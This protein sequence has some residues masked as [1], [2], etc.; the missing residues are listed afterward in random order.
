MLSA[1]VSDSRYAALNDYALN[2][3]AGACGTAELLLATALPPGVPAQLGWDLAGASA[4]A[5]ADAAATAAVL[6][7]FHLSLADLAAAQAGLAA[8]GVG[9]TV[10]AAAESFGIYS[11]ALTHALS[12]VAADPLNSTHWSSLADAAVAALSGTQSATGNGTSLGGVASNVGALFSYNGPIPIPPLDAFVAAHTLIRGLFS[13]YEPAWAAYKAV[14]EKLGYNPLGNMVELGGVAFVPDSPGVRSMAASLAARHVSWS[15]RYRGAFADV[16]T[17]RDAAAGGDAVVGPWAVVVFDEATPAAL[18]YTIRMRFTLVPDTN[19]VA[20][21][22]YGGLGSAYLKYY[23]SGFLSLQ[24][25]IDEA[26]LAGALGPLNRTVGNGT[27]LLW[28]TPFPVFSFERN[29]FYESSGPLLGLVMCLSLVYPVG[30]LI[31]ALVEEKESGLRELMRVSG[32]CHWALGAAWALTYVV[33]FIAVSIAATVVLASSVFPHTSVTILW[34]LLF[35]FMLSCVPLCFLVSTAFR[36]ARLASIFGPF[37]LF[38]L[39]LPRYI[40]FR[41]SAGQAIGG[42]RAACLLAPT[43]FTFAADALSR[44]EAG[45]SGVTTAN[46]LDGPLPVGECMAWMVLDTMLY[47]LLASFFDYLVPDAVRSGRFARR[48]ACWPWRSRPAAALFPV[49]VE[50]A[51]TPASDIEPPPP[52]SA[53]VVVMRSLCKE[54]DNGVRAVSDLNLTLFDNQITAFLGHNGAGKT[55]SISMLTGALQATSGVIEVC[56]VDMGA[57]WRGARGLIG[58][59]PQHNVLFPLLSVAEHLRL[60]AV[61]KGV[62]A[63]DIPG[64]VA[65]LMREVG[66]EDKAHAASSALS[67][68]MKRR[69]QLAVALVG[70]PRLLLCDEPTSGQDPLSRRKTWDLLRRVRA[71]RCVLLTTHYLDEADLLADRVAILSEGRLRAAG[72]P[73]FLKQRLGGGN[74]LSVTSTQPGAPPSA[75]LRALIAEHAPGAALIRSSGGELAWQVP[76][77]QRGCFAALLP[78]LERD[79]AAFGVGGFGISSATLEEVFL[80]LAS[81]AAATADAADFAAHATGKN[82]AAIE[83]RDMRGKSRRRVASASCLPGLSRDAAL[84]GDAVL[85]SSAP[86]HAYADAAPA[87][88]HDDADETDAPASVEKPSLERIPTVRDADQCQR[89]FRRAFTEM[90]RKR[91]RIARRDVKSVLSQVA[92]PTVAVALVLLVLKLDIDPVGP[93]LE[94]STRTLTGRNS[95]LSTAAQ[96]NASLRVTPVVLPAN[97]IAANGTGWVAGFAAPPMQLTPFAGPRNSTAMSLSLLQNR[98]MSKPYRFGAY[99]PGDVVLPRFTPAVCFADATPQDGAAAAGALLTAVADGRAVSA[100]LVNESATAGVS[101]LRELQQTQPPPVN[102][103]HN[104]S[105]PHSLPTFVSELHAAR[106]RTAGGPEL[107]VASH[108][109]PLT[110]EEVTT[111]ATFLRLLASFFVLIPFSYLPATYAAFVVRERAV[112]AKLQQLASGCGAVAYWVAAFAWEMLNHTAVVLACMILFAIFQIDVLIG[113]SDK[114]FGIFLLLIL[115]GLAVTPLSFVYSFLFESHAAA[116]VAIA[117]ANFVTG[118]CLVTA[119][120]IMSVTPSTVALNARLVQLFRIFPPFCLGEG[121]VGLATSSFDLS[122]ATAAAASATSGSGNSSTY[123]AAAGAAPRNSFGDL[124][125]M[126]SRNAFQWTILGRPLLLLTAECCFYFTVTL[127]IEMHGRDVGAGVARVLSWPR[128]ALA[129]RLY[130]TRHGRAPPAEDAPSAATA[131][132]DPEVLAERA[133][134]ESGQGD[135]DAVQVR[136]LRKVYPARGAAPAKVAVRDLWLGVR[137]GERFGLLGENGAGKTTTLSA[138]CCDVA[139]TAGDAI[140]GGASILHAPAAVQRQI[141]YCPQ[142]DPILDLLTVREH[143][144]LYARLKGLPERYVATASEATWRRVGLGP[145]ADRLAGTLSGGNKRKLSLAIA[146]VGSPAVLLC[147]EPS[148]GMDP[149]ARRHLWDVI[150]VSTADMAVVLTTHAMDECEA[151]CG[152][153]G[154]MVHGEMCCI[155]SAMALKE[156]YGDGYVIDAKAQADQGDALSAHLLARLPGA[157]CSERHAGKMRFTVPRAAGLPLSQLF[158]A[159]QDAPTEDWAVSQS[160]LEAVFCTVTAD[161][162]DAPAQHATNGHA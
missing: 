134:L 60:F 21:S 128:D 148:S 117:C 74:T 150:T 123:S 35:L 43:A 115:Y 59:C 78:A 162:T 144:E 106:L 124:S 32:L 14:K 64:E 77:S 75:A 93:S 158:A 8:G 140:V 91:A 103:L 79:A 90:M 96:Q 146:I 152:R 16:E 48:Q 65:Q 82:G 52:G 88:T 38:A 114:A 70:G 30:M 130:R 45:N 22:F 132:A 33:L 87:T 73:L 51:R 107:V 27:G 142:R 109:L 156:R 80:R 10:V 41:T 68:G 99:V 113:T 63:R 159:L 19:S 15:G 94:L 119:S 58:V 105:L 11:P 154:I 120:F 122:G 83:M 112:G 92:L 141:G 1:I 111:L 153:I 133:R 143:L 121:L 104:T 108:P 127:L 57:N 67:G 49:D 5:A 126:K 71:G 54:F 97:D 31:K 62:A 100:A 116:Q 131:A 157:V 36:R 13:R 102:V 42:K 3:T 136:G 149:Q 28:G 4:A 12:S 40:F 139:P 69:L 55:T 20:S 37:A 145:F 138:L 76:S 86:E 26:A 110:Q 147:D 72:S 161:A 6:K 46:Y 66:L 98:Q 118:F 17:A 53:P 101:L 160:S 84:L 44:Y 9:D 125:L 7:A 137:S 61:L 89:S 2:N 135:A 50:A 25:A 129:A 23:T 29:S 81:E 95:L 85:D 47:S 151:L 24:R 34:L 56:G 155:G 39:V 18:R